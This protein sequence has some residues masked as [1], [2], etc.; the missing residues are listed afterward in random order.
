M[1]LRQHHAAWTRTTAL[2]AINLLFLMI[3]GFA[4]GD[5]LFHGMPAWFPGKFGNTILGIFPG[6]KGSFFLLTASETLGFILAAIALARAEFLPRRS[7][8]FLPIAV[9][10]S[11]LVFVQLS[12]G[13]WMTSDF[14]GCFQQFLY[15]S[16]TLVALQFVQRPAIES[17]PEPNPAAR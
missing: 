7:V 14:N 2:L 15:F 12:L 10:W 1:T 3:W 11:L 16:G 8:V 6:V 9:A 5:K 17:V 13:L 4:G